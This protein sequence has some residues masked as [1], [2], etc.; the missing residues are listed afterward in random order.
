MVTNGRNFA[1][2]TDNTRQNATMIEEMTQDHTQALANLATATQSDREA[3]TN[4]TSTNATLTAQLIE[5]Q[6]KMMKAES[7]LATMKE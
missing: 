3:F 1:N 6:N 7:D 5:M 4:L 2:Y